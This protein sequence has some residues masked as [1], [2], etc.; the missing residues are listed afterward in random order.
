MLTAVKWATRLGRWSL[1]GISVL[2]ALGYVF[3]CVNVVI[4]PPFGL[5]AILSYA[6]EINGMSQVTWFQ[7]IAIFS[8]VPVLILLLLALALIL[9]KVERLFNTRGHGH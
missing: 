6:D 4:N 5:K 9:R 8:V 7:T 2:L 3:T 1:L